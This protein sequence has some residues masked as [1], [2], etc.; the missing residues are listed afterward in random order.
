GVGLGADALQATGDEALLVAHRD[1]DRDELLLAGGCGGLVDLGGAHAARS[2]ERVTGWSP[3]S[4][5]PARMRDSASKV[6]ACRPGGPPLSW[7]RTTAP[8]WAAPRTR[9]AIASGVA[10]ASQS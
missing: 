1:D 5:N 3:R 2:V 4:S 6:A 10:P 9:S 8:G 7:N